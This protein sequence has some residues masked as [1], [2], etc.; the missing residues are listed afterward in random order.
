MKRSHAT[1]P[2]WPSNEASP[3]PVFADPS[4]LFTPPARDSARTLFVPLHYEPNYAYPLIVWLHGPGRDERQLLEMMPLVSRRN[5]VAVAPRGL[6]LREDERRGEF[7]GWSQSVDHIQEAEERIF[8]G[9]EAAQRKLNV[10]PDRVFLA[11]FDSGGT[12]ALRVALG[13][14]W[15]FAGVLSIGGAFP[16]GQT[17]LGRWNQ[18][19]NLVVFMA[20]GRE[21]LEYPPARACEDLRLLHAAGISVTLRQYPQGHY[22]TSQILG[23]VDRWIMEQVAA[24]SSASLG[25]GRPPACSPRRVDRE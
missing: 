14:P 16:S 23:D 7:C 9:I 21:S 13:H 10:A 20:L 19:R 6:C 12:M 8:D 3:G 15:R 17:P 5:Y 25:S 22:L 18:A 1:E 11:G 4:G 24:G 2:S